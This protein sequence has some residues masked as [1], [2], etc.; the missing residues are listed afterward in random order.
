ML[1][2]KGTLLNVLLVGCC[3]NKMSF[4]L[5]QNPNPDI[6]ID[7]SASPMCQYKSPFLQ[8]QM[9][10]IVRWLFSVIMSGYPSSLKCKS[11]QFID[12]K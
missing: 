6:L 1:N 11:L 3:W 5:H 8:T 7:V 4:Q 12:S 2:S 10:S 9:L